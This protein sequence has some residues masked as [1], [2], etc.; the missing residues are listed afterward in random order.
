M[1][2]IDWVIITILGLLLGFCIG[3]LEASQ[4]ISGNMGWL[5]IGVYFLITMFWS[6]YRNIQ[7]GKRKKNVGN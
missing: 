3:W 6:I 4:H 2:S 1:T 7:K 5:I